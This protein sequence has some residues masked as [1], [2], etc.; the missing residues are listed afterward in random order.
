MKLEELTKEELIS[1]IKKT[2]YS[3]PNRRELLNVRWETLVAEAQRIREQAI[4]ESQKWEGIKTL[5]AYEHWRDAQLL[6]D[7][8]MALNKKAEV[9]FDELLATKD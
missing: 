4:Q 2:C 9:V 6:F 5:E 1:L 8:G 7:K 3:L